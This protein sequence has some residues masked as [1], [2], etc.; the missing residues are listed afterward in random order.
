[1]KVKE[2]MGISD[3]QLKKFVDDINDVA[4]YLETIHPALQADD[5]KK[6]LS[7]VSLRIVF[8]MYC[9]QLVG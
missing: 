8:G 1:M 7:E 4:T 6:T 3:T 2:N 9:D 5:V